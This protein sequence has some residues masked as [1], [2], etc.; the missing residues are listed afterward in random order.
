MSLTTSQNNPTTQ[1]HTPLVMD[2]VQAAALMGL[3]AHT[4]RKHRTQG[5]GCAYIKM[6]KTVRYRL[7]DIQAYI[8]KSVVT[9]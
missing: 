1:A 8:E 4:L 9:R 6:G 7:A 5:I 2:D 3:S